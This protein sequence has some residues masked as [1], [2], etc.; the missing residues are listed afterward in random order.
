MSDNEPGTEAT[1]G[2]VGAVSA[3]V[4][5]T[6][7][8]TP[9]L[10]SA[11]A[12]PTRFWDRPNVERYFSPLVLPLIAVFLIVVYVL[13]VSRLFLSAP[14][15][16]AV[17]LGTIITIVI[18]FGATM[19]AVSPRMRSGSIALITVGFIALIV[20][21]GSVNLGHSEPHGEAEG[22]AL[23]CDTPAAAT[24]TFVAGPNNSL[25]FDPSEANAQTGLAKIEVND[26]TSTEHTFLFEDQQ[27]QH[28]KQVVSG[29]QQSSTCVALFPEAGDY[30]FYCDIPGHR[31]AGMEGVV[32]VEGDPVT[33]AEAEAAAG[34][35]GGGEGSGGETTTTAP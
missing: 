9:A 15:N 14:G 3:T 2:E 4:D 1:E 35:G 27:T 34:G 33:L 18:L 24:L 12:T 25:S 21:A 28:E 23:P 17:V 7:E 13:N 31:Q 16:V 10:P 11:E 22:G 30:V 29:G 8:S 32:H 26:A 5:A 19:L 20:A 6:E